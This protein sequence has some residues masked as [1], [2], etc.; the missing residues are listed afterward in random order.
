MQGNTFALT[1][2]LVGVWANGWQSLSRSAFCSERN[3]NLKVQGEPM[4]ER[5]FQAIHLLV[6][7]GF[8]LLHLLV[9]AG[10]ALL[11]FGPKNLP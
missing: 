7:A 6:I 5:L 3:K 4:F 2:S 1:T 11:L 8:A 10:F 9:I